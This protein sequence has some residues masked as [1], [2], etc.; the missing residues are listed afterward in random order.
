MKTKNVKHIIAS[1]VILSGMLSC[2]FALADN[3][4]D[5]QDIA[6]NK[7]QADNSVVKLYNPS[8]TAEMDNYKDGSFAGKLKFGVSLTKNVYSSTGVN[9]SNNRDFSFT[10]VV[11]YMGHVKGLSPYAEVSYTINNVKNTLHW[12]DN[13]DYD[14]GVLASIKNQYDLYIED[15][16]TFDSNT[17]HY[18]VGGDFQFSNGWILGMFYNDSSKQDPNGYLGLKAGY[19]F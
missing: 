17:R 8:V 4:A 19:M 15:D 10:E 16:D 3:K 2:S 5:T 11:G 9:I 18:K 7:E 12:K 1:A 6:V 14:F 13:T